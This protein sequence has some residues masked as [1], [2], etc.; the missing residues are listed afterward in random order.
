MLQ[1]YINDIKSRCGIIPEVTAYD[2]VISGL[3]DDFE[4]VLI[5]SGVKESVINDEKHRQQI[6]TAATLYVKAHLGDDRS[7][8]ELYLKLCE[9]KIFRLTLEGDEDVE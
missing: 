8:T 7:D 5:S 4:D 6:I 3:L 2:D 1:E 9:K